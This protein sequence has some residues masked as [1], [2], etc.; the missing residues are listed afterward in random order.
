MNL[1]KILILLLV[2]YLFTPIIALAG[3]EITTIKHAKVLENNDPQ[4]NFFIYIL[5]LACKASEDKYGPCKLEASDVPM[6][7]ERQLKSLNSGLLDITWTASSN[8]RERQARAIKFPLMAGML[9]YRVAVYNKTVKKQFSKTASTNDLKK[10]ILVQGLDWP[11]TIILK[12]HHFNVH[13]TNWYEHLYTDTAKGL[14]DY[15]LR[16]VFEVK[17]ELNNYQSPN[18][19][20]DKNH[21][22]VYPLHIYYFVAKDNT[23][24]AER[25]EYGLNKLN[26]NNNYIS[27]LVNFPPHKNS[28]PLL[29]LT[30]RK[31]HIIDDTKR[32]SEESVS[33]MLEQVRQASH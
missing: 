26:K 1:N 19:E 11:D 28:L 32:I 18:L 9:G 17:S 31:I 8:K 24:L 20:M 7:Q 21:L 3:P 29:N 15:I 14:Y 12:K 25:I 6:L 23:A 4:K 13:E 16:G 27:L 5:D 33:A 2:T 30:K 22:I 10:L